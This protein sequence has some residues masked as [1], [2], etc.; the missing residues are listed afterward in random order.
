M[1]SDIKKPASTQ[2]AKKNVSEPKQDSVFKAPIILRQPSSKMATVGGRLIFQVATHAVPMPKY[3]WYHNGQMIGGANGPRFMIP[4]VRQS[5]VGLYYCEIKNFVGTVTSKQVS[6]MIMQAS[7]PDFEITPESLTVDEG[8]RIL[9]SI[10]WAGTPPLNFNQFEYQWY[11][12]ERKIR[13]ANKAELDIKYADPRLNGEFSLKLTLKTNIN[14]Y[15][16]S[17]AATLTVNAKKLSPTQIQ[18]IIPA[19]APPPENK[20][21]VEEKK[22]AADQHSADPEAVSVTL[23]RPAISPKEAEDSFF[24]FSE[25]SPPTPHSTL[26]VK[27]EAHARLE[28]KNTWLK[29]TLMKLIQIKLARHKDKEQQHSA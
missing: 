29:K 17:E 21:V 10:K 2:A 26:D 7:I 11:C 1:A 22:P 18:S 16:I 20:A 4:K 6:C 25:E 19:P 15:K 9:F 24:D 27:N 28:A 13:G 5:D 8:K 12:N 23:I 14:A 3:Q